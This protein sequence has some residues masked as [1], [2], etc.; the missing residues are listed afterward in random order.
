MGF[1]GVVNGTII[2]NMKIL[3]YDYNITNKYIDN[4]NF[5][6]AKYYNYHFK[7]ILKKK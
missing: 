2:K 4:Y 5:N 1:V 7:N 3:K 6:N